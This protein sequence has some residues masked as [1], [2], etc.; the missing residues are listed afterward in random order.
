[1]TRTP[2]ILFMEVLSCLFLP[3]TLQCDYYY[4]YAHF[5]EKNTER[6]IKQHA[7]IIHLDTEELAHKSVWLKS[8]CSHH[9][10]TLQKEIEPDP[11]C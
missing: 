10:P 8:V 5:K 2:I 7:H 9:S 4:N 1:M 11:L 3:E 6:E